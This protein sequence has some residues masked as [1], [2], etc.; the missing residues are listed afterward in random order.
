MHRKSSDRIR[1]TLVPLYLLCGADTATQK[2]VAGQHLRGCVLEP[3]LFALCSTVLLLPRSRECQVDETRRND[4][5]SPIAA[6]A[7]VFVALKFS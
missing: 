7:V 2:G 4:F 6:H 1:A 5:R 3:R